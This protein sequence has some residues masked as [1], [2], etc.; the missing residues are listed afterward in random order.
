M[1]DNTKSFSH[2][3]FILPIYFYFPCWQAL[4]KDLVCPI[5]KPGVYNMLDLLKE[6]KLIMEE[7]EIK[8]TTA[9]MFIGCNGRQVDRW[10]KGQAIPTMLYREAIKRGIRRMKRL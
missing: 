7:R 9:A 2:L 4:T 6:L 5:L 1:S 10:L 8:A 3:F